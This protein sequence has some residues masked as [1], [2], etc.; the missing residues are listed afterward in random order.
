MADHLKGPDGPGY[1]P[2]LCEIARL[3]SDFS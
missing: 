2:L 1:S 3:C